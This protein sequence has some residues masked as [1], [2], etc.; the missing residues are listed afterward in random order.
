MSY[1]SLEIYQLA[2]D[3]VI[4]I[5][6]MTLN[7]LPGFEIYETGSQIRRSIKSVKSNIVEGYG[8][9]SYKQDFI[10]FLIF[11]H[12]SLDETIDHLETLFKTKSLRDFEWYENPIL[13]VKNKPD[14]ILVSR[15]PYHASKKNS[16]P[17][18]RGCCS[19]LN[20]LNF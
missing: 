14:P 5:H 19:F 6:E 4:K 11:A 10:H 13:R 17:S 20:Q 1:R 12:A 15:I 16:S 2:D 3:L 7:D 9:R 8:R 18:N